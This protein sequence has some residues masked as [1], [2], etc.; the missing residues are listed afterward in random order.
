MSS[1]Y[2]EKIT[3]AYLAEELNISVSAVSLALSGRV[4]VSD[5]LRARVVARARELGYQPNTSAVALRTQRTRVLGLLLRNLSNPYFLDVI[6]G[7]DE[8]CASAGY[9]VM[10]GSARY[11]SQR[12]R[13]LLG[14]F[15]TRMIDGLA[16]A[17]IGDGSD[18]HEWSRKTGRPTLILNSNSPTTGPLLASIEV[19]EDAAVKLAV[20]HLLRLGHRRIGLLAVPGRKEPHPNR[21]QSFLAMQWQ[22][23]FSAR[24]IEA[25]HDFDK[26]RY[27]VQRELEAGPGLRPTAVISNSDYMAQAVYLAARDSGLSVPHDLSVVGHDDLPTSQLL[28]PSLTSLHIP[29]RHLG[30]MAAKALVAGVENRLMPPSILLI[31]TL[32][33]RDST[34]APRAGD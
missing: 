33:V 14:T 27:A 20:D 21:T 15:A 13:E 22:L 30:E 18:A 9:E 32:V 25:E 19:D 26:V 16:I 10:M 34:A 5:K 2:P 3:Q 31:P 4:G 17:P 23:G 6:N 24:V 29:R 7:F 8:T 12:E 11:D 1:S 28:A